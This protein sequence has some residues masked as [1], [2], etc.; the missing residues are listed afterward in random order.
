MQTYQ[1]LKVGVLSVED[2]TTPDAAMPQVRSGAQ[3]TRATVLAEM[4]DGF[5]NPPI[6]SI[7]L[8]TAGKAYL[9]VAKAGAATDFQKVT[10]TAAD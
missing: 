4:D 9:R 5:N 8:S 2:K 1:E 7:Y 6:G 10:T 3:T